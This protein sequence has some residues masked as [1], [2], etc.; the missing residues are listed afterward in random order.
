[1]QN[2][3]QDDKDVWDIKRRIKVSLKKNFTPPDTELGYYKI[4]RVLGKGAYG[5][6]NIALQKLTKKIC[7]VK[8]INMSKVTTESYRKKIV[9]EKMILKEVRH[10]NIVKLYETIKHHERGNEYELMFME[11]CTGGNLLH[12]LRRRRHLDENIAKLFMW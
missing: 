12:Y 10:P 2:A 11:I 7:A 1:M 9:T 3:N 5:K 6:V 8:S 4:G